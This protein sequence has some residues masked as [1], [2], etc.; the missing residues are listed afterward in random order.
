M[1]LNFLSVVSAI[2]ILAGSQQS[3]ADNQTTTL[4]DSE[5]AISPQEDPY[6]YLN[7]SLK[8]LL[9]IKVTIASNTENSVIDSP[10]SVTVYLRQE[11]LNMGL[12]NLDELLNFI[13]G[14]YSNRN[15]VRGQLAIFRGRQ[16]G[17]CSNGVLVLLNGSRANNA[18]CGGAFEHL[19]YLSLADI[20]RVE[21]IRGP[22]SA[23]YGSNAMLGVI[24]VITRKTGNQVNIATGNIGSKEINVK[25][26]KE[27]VKV[28]ASL[29]VRYSE[30]E[31]N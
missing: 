1:K 19:S 24:N 12:E 22:G 6:N 14:V 28:G 5:S 16:S 8:E 23:I 4:L 13:P 9:N 18:L 26:S 25:L 21:V 20:E 31:G 10:S 17:D 15:D 7:L 27:I 11:I 2:Y 30:D 29:F 3:L